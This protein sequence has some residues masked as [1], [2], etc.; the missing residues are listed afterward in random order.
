MI[1]E[2]EL[3]LRID[4]AKN[5]RW[6]YLGFVGAYPL[7]GSRSITTDYPRGVTPMGNPAAR[8]IPVAGGFGAA[9]R[10]SRTYGALGGVAIVPTKK[11][12]YTG[13]FEKPRVFVTTN[14]YAR[15][16]PKL[17]LYHYVVVDLTGAHLDLGAMRALGI[18]RFLTVRELRSVAR[19]YLARPQDAREPY[20]SPLH[21][22][23]LAGL[24]PAWIGS[25]EY[26]KLRDDG[27]AYAKALADA[28]VEVEFQILAGHVH[29]S[30]AFTR[31]LPSAKAY[32]RE[33]I[34]A[35]ARALHA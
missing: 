29:P 18:P 31:L 15:R 26:D 5:A 17:D 28:G 7:R 34:A 19:T 13:A 32:E 2:I 22:E 8:V 21:A 16:S 35:L 27:V 12:A 23:S 11:D 25:C 14:G 10:T 1:D 4:H 6:T 20:A 9:Y 30:F 33:A 3:A 24:P